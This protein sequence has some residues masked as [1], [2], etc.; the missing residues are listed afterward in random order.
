[1]GYSRQHSVI[2]LIPIQTNNYVNKK[3]K[4]NV[5]T[6]KTKH[7]MQKAKQEYKIIAIKIKKKWWD[8]WILRV[9]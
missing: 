8:E 9:A 3:P 6:M 7:I 1:M 4:W 5:D 2:T